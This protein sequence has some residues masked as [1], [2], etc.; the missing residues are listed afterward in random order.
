MQSYVE[1]DFTEE[2]IF[3]EID[4][5]AEF[6][7]EDYQA[8]TSKMYT[9]EETEQAIYQEVSGIPGLKPFVLER[10]ENVLMQLDSLANTVSSLNASIQSQPTKIILH[11][12]YP[13]PFN[14]ATNIKY[15][16]PG[17]NYVDL[18]IYNLLGQKVATLIS[19][20]HSQG[21]Y[22]IEWD[23]TGLPSGIY[24]YQLEYTYREVKKMLVVK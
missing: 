23:A 6:I 20:H 19:S 11:P 7:R 22:Q 24:Y 16:L 21:N 5:L 8:D 10:R 18:S 14:P 4:R 2:K 12:N 1:N 15:E 9:N 13:N 17:T 3:S